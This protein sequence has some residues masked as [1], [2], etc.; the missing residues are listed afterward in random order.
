MNEM[1][2]VAKPIPQDI[3]NKVERELERREYRDRLHALIKEIR[4]AGFLID[5]G[6][7]REGRDVIFSQ[8]IGITN[9]ELEK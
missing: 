8:V 6:Y 4:D 1:L 3:V 5:V 2:I 9:A 7:G